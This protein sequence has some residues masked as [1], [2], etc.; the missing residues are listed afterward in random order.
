MKYP[1]STVYIKIS[2]SLSFWMAFPVI[3]F[4]NGWAAPIPG[5]EQK[6]NIDKL[7][8]FQSQEKAQAQFG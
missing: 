5:K 7:R 1:S 8:P 2:L 4:V 6:L 3:A